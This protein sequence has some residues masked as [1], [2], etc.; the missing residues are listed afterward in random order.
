M[1]KQVALNLRYMSKILRF[2][3]HV[4]EFAFNA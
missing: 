3:V 4:A 1:T 2:A